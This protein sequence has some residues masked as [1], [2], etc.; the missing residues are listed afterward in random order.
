MSKLLT[1][2]IPS[3]NRSK[4]LDRALDSIYASIEA[5]E[6]TKEVDV[7]V[8]DDHSTDDLTPIVEKYRD[9]VPALVFKLHDEK[10]GVAEVA[11]LR[12]LR[13]VATPYVWVVGNDDRVTTGSIRYALDLVAIRKPAFCLFNFVAERRSNGIVY[14]TIT[15]VSDVITFETGE[16]LFMNLGLVT[17]TTTFPCLCFEVAPLLQVDLEQV[18]ATSPIYSHTVA[19]YLAYFN[20]RCCFVNR[21]MAVFNH[22][23]ALD[24]CHKLVAHNERVGRIPFYNWTIGLM[25]HLEH[26]SA[27]TGASLEV[28]SLIS[29]DESM[30]DTHAVKKTLIVYFIVRNFLNQMIQEVC[31]VR[32]EYCTTIHLSAEDMDA[33]ERF[34]LRCGA[35]DLVGLFKRAKAVL[36]N[37]TLHAHERSDL[38]RGLTEELEEAEKKK[39][40]TL[41]EER[42]FAVERQGRA[43]DVMVRHANSGYKWVDGVC[44]GPQP[45]GSALA[46]LNMR[47]MIKAVHVV[48]RQ[49]TEADELT[50]SALVRNCADAPGGVVPLSVR[51]MAAHNRPDMVIFNEASNRAAFS[52]TFGDRPSATTAR[53][54]SETCW[55][56]TDLSLEDVCL[57]A[58]S[59]P[60]RNS[61]E[62]FVNV[63]SLDRSGVSVRTP[64]RILFVNHT[65]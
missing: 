38:L 60:E 58:R 13:H 18:I 65:S 29:E 45:D 15:S 43:F 10:C 54:S 56:R 22:N 62:V 59:H 23:E 47:R 52:Q 12:G 14:E 48:T 8:V 16:R 17:S 24:E 4:D 11:M 1:I 50:A 57:K 7:L 9:R 49:T 36:A 34:L 28:L 31:S 41:E 3:Y 55:W 61:P 63:A 19:F 44:P 20:R 46:R 37:G 25:R 51:T 27:A 26:I 35:A 39:I 30:K 5:G 6:C 2:F 53:S 64:L 21:I 42:R 32:L 40:A 33:C